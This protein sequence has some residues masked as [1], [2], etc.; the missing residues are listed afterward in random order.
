[1]ANLVKMFN[2]LYDSKVLVSHLQ[3]FRLNLDAQKE[4]TKLQVDILSFLDGRFFF[5]FKFQQ[6]YST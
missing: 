1:M 5:N 4:P 6:N 3:G 2:F